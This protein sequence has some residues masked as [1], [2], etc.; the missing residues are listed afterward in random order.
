DANVHD[1]LEG[2][3]CTVSICSGASFEGL[4]HGTPAVL[5]GRADFAACAWSVETE[6]DAERA[7]AE[8]GVV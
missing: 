6:E 4:F 3:Y 7:L 2:A 1:L 5:F 8:I